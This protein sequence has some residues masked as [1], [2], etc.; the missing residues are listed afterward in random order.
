MISPYIGAK[1]RVVS[2]HHPALSE[3]VGQEGEITGIMGNQIWVRPWQ[4]VPRKTRQGTVMASAEP[5]NLFGIN[6]VELC[7]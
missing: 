4:L 1:V 5:R 7:Q 3:F 6:Q 2:V